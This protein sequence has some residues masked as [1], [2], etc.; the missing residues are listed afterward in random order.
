MTLD[1]GI[2]AE[3]LGL[4]APSLSAI[5]AANGMPAVSPPATTSN[6]SKPASRSTI[7]APKSIRVRRTRGNEISLRQSV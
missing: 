3:A 2:A 5:Q 6:C 4:L 7:E 1:L